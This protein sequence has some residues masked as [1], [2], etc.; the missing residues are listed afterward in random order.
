MLV[1]AAALCFGCALRGYDAS[2][3]SEPTFRLSSLEQSGDPARRAST[4]LLLE[5][6]V[7]DA[8]GRPS[9]ALSQYERALQVDPNNPYAYLVLARHHA[10]GVEP[11]RALVFLDRADALLGQEAYVP[12]GVQAH[13]VGLRGAALR[14][15][16][17][18]DAGNPLLARARALDPDAWSDARLSAR[19]LQ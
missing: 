19:E 3:R 11:A 12:P 10:D 9:K 15:S 2:P 14:A 8:E 1:A 16:G 6:L 5:G 18:A 7:R 4:R 13:L 17:H